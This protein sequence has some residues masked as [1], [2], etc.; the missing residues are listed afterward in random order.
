MK[1][2]ILALITCLLLAATLFSCGRDEVD[3]KFSY[4]GKTGIE[5]DVDDIMPMITRSSIPATDDEKIIK[6]ITIFFFTNDPAGRLVATVHSDVAPGVKTFYF[7]IPAE[8]TPKVKY[9]TLI[10]GNGDYY[11][12]M[13]VNN[14]P[15][16]L[17]SLVQICRNHGWYTYDEIKD[18]L[19]A[20]LPSVGGKSTSGYK[21]TMPGQSPESFASTSQSENAP[22]PMLGTLSDGT[23]APSLFRCTSH[24]QKTLGLNIKFTRRVARLD[25]VLTKNAKKNLEIEWVK[26]VHGRAGGFFFNNTFPNPAYV[27]ESVDNLP[28]VIPF[29]TSNEQRVEAGLYAFFNTVQT[30]TQNDKVTTYLLI[31]GYY[32]ADGKSKNTTNATYYRF[33]MAK[34][35]DTQLLLPNHCYIGKIYGCSGPG[36]STPE[37]AE[38]ADTPKLDYGVDD[39]W[40][41]DIGG[42]PIVDSKG[43][44]MKVSRRMLTFSGSKDDTKRIRVDVKNGLNWKYYWTNSQGDVKLPESYFS[45]EKVDRR[46]LS[47]TTLQDNDEDFI[48]DATLVV[49]AT[50]GSVSSSEQLKCEVNLMQISSKVESKLLLV[51]NRLGTIETDVSGFGARLKFSVKT[52]SMRG[53]WIVEDVDKF[54]ENSGV[55]FTEY[56]SNNGIL[57]IDIPANITSPKRYFT[58][59]VRRTSAGTVD[60]DVQPVTIKISQEKSAGLLFPSPCPEEGLRVNAF[61]PKTGNVN[62]YSVEKKFFVQLADP[63]NYVYDVELSFDKR[64]EAYLVK[65]SSETIPM[66]WPKDIKTVKYMSANKEKSRLE[67]LAHASQFYLRCFRAG[68][69]DPTLRGTLKFIARPKKEGAGE[70]METNLDIIIESSCILGDAVVSL[71]ENGKYIIADRNVGAPARIDTLGN[72]RPARGYF[73]SAPEFASSNEYDWGKRDSR[74]KGSTFNWDNFDK[75]ENITNK[76]IEPYLFGDFVYEG[77]FVDDEEKFGFGYKEEDMEKWTIFD[78]EAWKLVGPKIC[79]SKKRPFIV[80]E[81]KSMDGEYI[82]TYLPLGGIQSVPNDA[83]CYYWSSTAENFYSAKHLVLR[84]SYFEIYYSDYKYSSFLRPVRL[85]TAEEYNNYKP[86]K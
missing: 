45:I 40:E 58:F 13:E 23:G 29:T 51:D 71:G 77:K 36:E 78:I 25:L 26:V 47:I 19:S 12:G 32:T 39:E 24:N 66:S 16:N 83:R 49:E 68:P 62:G 21:I 50:G 56:G 30:V 70:M 18:N 34:N 28:A 75:Q 35:G 59:I 9:K 63:A 74:W 52:G 64:F 65:E 84:T 3:N 20:S 76:V 48:R 5:F 37:E 41:S 1:K 43:N 44:W 42:D 33:N 8:I 61:S 79:Y 80:S 81:K 85:L 17:P 2:G 11:R 86:R 4:Q 31:K 72:F 15:E 38:N 46:T 6:D 60:K 22:L 67:N 14:Y 69:G 54:G 82:A 7:N 73:N 27:K 55:S 53:G 57:F 10:V